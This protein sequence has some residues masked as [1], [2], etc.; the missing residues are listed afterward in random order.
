MSVLSVFEIVFW[1]ARF[2][3]KKG[4]GNEKLVDE[5][6]EEEWKKKM[7]KKIS[8]LK[9]ARN[10]R[11]TKPGLKNSKFVLSNSKESQFRQ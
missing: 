3:L 7:E 9:R 2:F 5:N 11:K 6:R 8:H 4:S 1:L 10:S